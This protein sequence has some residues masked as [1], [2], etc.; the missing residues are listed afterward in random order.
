MIHLRDRL[1]AARDRRQAMMRA[2]KCIDTQSEPGSW[3]FVLEHGA[4]SIRVINPTGRETIG[5]IIDARLALR[6]AARLARSEAAKRGH[7]TRWA[8]AGKQARETFG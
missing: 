8:K 3:A 6:K 2:A 4:H 7:S 5:E 1:N